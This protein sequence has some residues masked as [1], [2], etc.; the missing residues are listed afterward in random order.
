MWRACH[1]GMWVCVCAGV[2]AARAIPP[3]S[4]RRAPAHVCT[5]MV[6]MHVRMRVRGVETDRKCDSE[7]GRR[8]C[9]C[10]G[11]QGVSPMPG[12]VMSC[13]L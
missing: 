1:V 3:Y 4:D 11:N 8:K 7:C 6:M 5:L 2:L 10:G 12:A 13:M 9:S